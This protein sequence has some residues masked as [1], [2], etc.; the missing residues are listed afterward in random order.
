MFWNRGEKS[1]TDRILEKALGD[2]SLEPVKKIVVNKSRLKDALPEEET[3]AQD[4][5][6]N[7]QINTEA[8]LETEDEHTSESLSE[9]EIV[10]VSVRAEDSPIVEMETVLEEIEESHIS[11]SPDPILETA[12]EKI[13]DEAFDLLPPLKPKHVPVHVVDIPTVIPM[14]TEDGIAH[15]SMPQEIV[16]RNEEIRDSAEAKTEMEVSNSRSA[17]EFNSPEQTSQNEDLPQEELVVNTVR[18]VELSP[19]ERMPVHKDQ[20]FH[21]ESG[22]TLKSIKDLIHGLETMNQLTWNHHVHGGRNDFA[23][24]VEHVF[25]DKSLGHAM[26]DYNNAHTLRVFLRNA[27]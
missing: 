22:E 14:A 15:V 1:I 10:H 13:E 3:V 25:H 20:Y 7:E 11:H 2:S 18:E 12:E 19:L 23:N 16:S 6:Q 8:L 24:W 5:A 17:T 21:L 9:E 27:F 4:E 26:R